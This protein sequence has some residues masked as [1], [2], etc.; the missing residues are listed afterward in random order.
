MSS[1]LV[2]GFVH[3]IRNWLPR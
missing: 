1:S 2:I 3:F